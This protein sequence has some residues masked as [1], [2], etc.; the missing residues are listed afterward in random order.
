[1]SDTPITEP[2]DPDEV[3]VVEPEPLEPD[4]DEEPDD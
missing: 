2:I 3:P 1:M 4:P